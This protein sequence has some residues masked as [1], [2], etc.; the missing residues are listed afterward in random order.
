[1]PRSKEDQKR[2]RETPEGAIK[3][4]AHVRRARLRAKMACLRH[5]GGNP[6]R[7]ACCGESNVGFLSLDHVNNDGNLHRKTEAHKNTPHCYFVLKRAGFPTTPAIQVLCF[8]CNLGRENN[9]GICPH[10]Q[11]TAG[12]LFRRVERAATLPLPTPEPSP[13]FPE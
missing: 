7:C 11:M 5:Y 2:A 4:R 1:M 6:P 9:G 10:K 3:N 13:L 12:N 8:N